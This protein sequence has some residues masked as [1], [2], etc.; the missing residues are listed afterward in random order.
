[1][2]V[3]FIYGVPNANSGTGLFTFPPNYRGLLFSE[4]SVGSVG[5]VRYRGF[6]ASSRRGKEDSLIGEYGETKVFSVPDFICSVK[7]LDS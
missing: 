7:R 2:I 5:S 4:R 3:V 1:M 6:I